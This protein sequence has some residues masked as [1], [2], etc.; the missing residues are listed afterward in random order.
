[1]EGA[2]GLGMICLGEAEGNGIR[3]MHGFDIKT[4]TKTRENLD[5]TSHISCIRFTPH[6][7]CRRCSVI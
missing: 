7:Q 1:M 2:G 3:A 5:Q 6:L 4:D